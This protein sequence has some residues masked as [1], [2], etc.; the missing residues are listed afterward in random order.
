MSFYFPIRFTQGDILITPII[1]AR[2]KEWEEGSH[3]FNNTILP[4]WE[5]SSLWNYSNRYVRI[6]S[7]NDIWLLSPEQRF[8]L[9]SPQLTVT[10]VWVEKVLLEFT[11]A[12]ELWHNARFR[13]IQFSPLLLLEQG[14]YFWV[15]GYLTNHIGFEQSTSSTRF[16]TQRRLES[17]RRNRSFVCKSF[18]NS[19]AKLNQPTL[20]SRFVIM[21][22]WPEKIFFGVVAACMHAIRYLLRNNT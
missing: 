4:S 15:S 10:L 7:N 6:Y 14:I 13:F 11:G 22:R 17:D 1:T 12:L 5:W 19:P 2:R 3:N 18:V 9:G 16:N 21:A 8:S 20:L